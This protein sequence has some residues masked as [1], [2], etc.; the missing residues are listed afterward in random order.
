MDGFGF[1]RTALMAQ[2]SAFSADPLFG[3]GRRLL[4]APALACG[5]GV[6]ILTSA[7]APLKARTLGEIT[8]MMRD[9]VDPFS[10]V[11]IS[12]SDPVFV[13]VDTWLRT[14]VSDPK[15]ASVLNGSRRTEVVR[16][17]GNCASGSSK[18]IY[19]TNG[20]ARPD[21]TTQSLTFSAN[22]ADTMYV[23]FE[24]RT[25]TA[26][27]KRLRS[28]DA[29]EP[30]ARLVDVF[31]GNT[32]TLRIMGRDNGPIKR[33]VEEARR[34]AEER[35]D[36][37][38]TIFKPEGSRWRV[39]DKVAK[40]DM[41][42][43]KHDPKMLAEIIEDLRRFFDRRDLYATKGRRWK[44][45]ILLYGPPGSGKSTLIHLLASHFGRSI[46]HAG[47]LSHATPQLAKNLPGN[48]FL[49]FEDVDCGPGVTRNSTDFG[50]V[51]NVL[52]GISDYQDGMVVIMTANHVGKIDP[53]LL[54]PGRMDVKFFVGQP[55]DEQC[56]AMYC[57]FFAASHE[58]MA[59]IDLEHRRFDYA[60]VPAARYDEAV[61]FVAA[62][63]QESHDGGL[64]DA[65]GLPMMSCAFIENVL[66]RAMEPEYALETLRQC[67]D[68]ARALSEEQRRDKDRA[69]KEEAHK[70][71]LLI[72]ASAHATA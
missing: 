70:R 24:G 41:A 16:T 40:Y 44:R 4:G 68:E 33:L 60:T 3:L 25:I 56:K 20:A 6:A 43:S 53:A 8:T 27:Y 7:I 17:V 62:L 42:N 49:V 9:L 66:G 10:Y 69:F 55:N 64:A 13:H 58:D 30:T 48:A 38:T 21:P 29:H 35:A 2:V 22:L 57:N 31:G 1:I 26:S 19:D 61:A 23:V 50:A 37:Y 12:S 11:E 51:L 46:A 5:V 52:D 32:L 15:R 63:K 28:S 71:G 45:G 39:D 65:F 54:R 36:A 47:S 34:E 14:A 67:I 72:E 18:R 59:R